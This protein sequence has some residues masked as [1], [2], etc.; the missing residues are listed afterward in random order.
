MK[1]ALTPA[2]PLT[3][4]ILLHYLKAID[5]DRGFTLLEALVAMFIITIILSFIAGPIVLTAGTRVKNQDTEQSLNLAQS[6]VE[7]TR[8]TLTQVATW[9]DPNLNDTDAANGVRPNS[10]GTEATLLALG[11]GGIP[12]SADSTLGAANTT[13]ITAVPAPNAI[14]DPNKL[15]TNTAVPCTDYRQMIAVDY[16][17]DP[18]DNQKVDFYVQVF[19]LND[20]DD[21]TVATTAATAD[22]IMGFDLGVRV[23]SDLAANNLANL[24]TTPMASTMTSG[25][26]SATQPITVYYTSLYRSENSRALSTLNLCTVPSINGNNTN[27]GGVAVAKTVTT[28]GFTNKGTHLTP[29]ASQPEVASAQSPAANTKATCGSEITYTFYSTTPPPSSP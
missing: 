23:Y 8:I 18:N 26:L 15:L 14:C 27:D 6:Y 11:P 10:G 16:D 9:T 1:P 24:T 22:E 7:Q 29:N 12:Y 13:A 19:R 21:D 28:A 20:V 4:A 5:R 17:Q 25:L 2:Q 3:R